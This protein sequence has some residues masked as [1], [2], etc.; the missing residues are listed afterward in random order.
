MTVLGL[1]NKESINNLW[2]SLKKQ[3]KDSSLYNSDWLEKASLEELEKARELVQQ[4]YRNP[5]LNLEYRSECWD[6]IL[7]MLDNAI[8]RRKWQGKEYGYPVHK[9]WYLP[10]DD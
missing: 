4:D 1:K 3:V 7:P 5:K 10:N 9:D 8:G 2:N 6:K